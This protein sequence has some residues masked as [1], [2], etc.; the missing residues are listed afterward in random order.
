MNREFEQ[1]RFARIEG[2]NVTRARLQSQFQDGINDLDELEKA[3]ALELTMETPC[4]PWRK[5]EIEQIGCREGT[6][7]AIHEFFGELRRQIAIVALDSNSPP[8]TRRRQPEGR[9]EASRQDG[10][11][12]Q[13]GIVQP[14][15][16]AEPNLRLRHFCVR[17][18]SSR[19]HLRLLPRNR[20]TR[21]IP[22]DGH[23]NT[24]RLTSELFRRNRFT[25]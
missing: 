24:V 15:E 20:S 21:L 2:R 4:T 25:H 1:Y 6:R 10:K 19:P 8:R 14:I 7:L 22:P 12:A 5:S 23:G 3:I 9:A 16:M 17:C 11:E 13:V 18:P